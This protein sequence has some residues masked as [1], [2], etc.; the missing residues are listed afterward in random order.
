MHLDR[1]SPVL[2]IQSHLNVGTL[3]WVN[4]SQLQ[5]YFRILLALFKQDSSMQVYL[6]MYYVVSNCIT[7]PFY[8]SETDVINKAF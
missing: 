5:Q 2:R 7:K 6:Q 8:S 3:P 4:L 1:V